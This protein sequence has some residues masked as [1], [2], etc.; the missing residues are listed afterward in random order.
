MLCKLLVVFIPDRLK[1]LL[2]LTVLVDLLLEL[3][4]QPLD[5]VL[6]RLDLG[7]LKVKTFELVLLRLILCDILHIHAL[8]PLSQLTELGLGKR[9]LLAAVSLL[10]LELDRVRL[11]LSLSTSSSLVSHAA[12]A[13]NRL[14]LHQRLTDNTS[15]RHLLGH[16]WVRLELFVDRLDYGSQRGTL[17]VPSLY[18]WPLVLNRD[19][20]E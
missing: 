6:E 7:L 10:F 11:L 8:D 3:V 13:A 18:S 12:N 2:L 4:F 17:P 15:H 1:L 14:L 16:G 19:W 20:V 9:H 5:R